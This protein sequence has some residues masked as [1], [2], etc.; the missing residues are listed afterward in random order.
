M[1]PNKAFDNTD[2]EISQKVVVKDFDKQKL[3]L[4][5]KYGDKKWIIEVEIKE[6][7]T[8]KKLGKMENYDTKCLF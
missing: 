5:E 1:W 6:I 8:T 2:L 7:K 4:T 3:E